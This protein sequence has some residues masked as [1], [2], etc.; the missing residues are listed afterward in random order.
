[1]NTFIVL[2]TFV[3]IGSCL[4]FGFW[5]S[6]HD[7]EKVVVAKRLYAEL[8]Q[9]IAVADAVELS[10]GSRAGIER[11]VAKTAYE[12]ATAFLLFSKEWERDSAFLAL[13]PSL[14]RAVSLLDEIAALKVT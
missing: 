12:N 10:H 8:P 2:A 1:M 14:R 13:F 11:D 9:K 7:N 6:R 5:R 4:A 3:A